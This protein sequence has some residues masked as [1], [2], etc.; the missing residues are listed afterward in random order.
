LFQ[1]TASALFLNEIATIAC[2][3]VTRTNVLYVAVDGRSR[4]GC[5]RAHMYDWP[6]RHFCHP[7]L[8]VRGSF[9]RLR[10]GI[11]AVLE[12]LLSY[13][14]APPSLPSCRKNQR[15]FSSEIC[16][17]VSPTILFLLYLDLSSSEVDRSRSREVFPFQI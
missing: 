2:T 6:F 10:A 11:P 7:A 5:Q 13:R 8:G 1:R 16:S 12:H 17:A 14:S 9:L 3:I 4:S 15:C